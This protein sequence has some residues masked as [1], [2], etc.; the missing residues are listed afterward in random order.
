MELAVYRV[1]QE[2]VAN[3]VQH[4]PAQNIH[5]ELHRKDTHLDLVVADDG[6]GFDPFSVQNTPETGHFGL[7]NL[8]DRILSLEGEFTLESKSHKGTRIAARV[9]IPSPKAAD[10]KPSTSARSVYQLNT[11]NR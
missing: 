2:S 7:V 10:A 4:A 3:A 11:G 1:V 8:L 6:V 9:P 5:V